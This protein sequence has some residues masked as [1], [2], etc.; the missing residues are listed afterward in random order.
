MKTNYAEEAYNP[1]GI[2]PRALKL[3]KAKYPDA[4]M[5]TDV[6]LDPYSR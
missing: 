5:C 4:T 2:V 1:E 6:A 3:I